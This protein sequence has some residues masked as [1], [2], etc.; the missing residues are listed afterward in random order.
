MQYKLD[1]AAYYYSLGTFVSLS[2]GPAALLSTDPPTKQSFFRL[3]FSL[4]ISRPRDLIVDQRNIVFDY[5]LTLLLR[6]IV[7]YM[8][9]E[10]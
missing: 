6:N 4:H 10:I 8:N 1:R 3:P 5:Y 9:S 7:C 2:D